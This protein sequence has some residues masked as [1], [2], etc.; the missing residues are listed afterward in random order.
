[1]KKLIM[2]IFIVSLTAGLYAQST[3][4]ATKVG[5]ELTYVNK[6]AKG[7]AT[8]YTKMIIKNVQGSGRNMTI[9]YETEL[10]DKNRK[11]LNPPQVMPLKVV[12]KDNV[13]TLDMKEMFA[14]PM[15]DQSIQIEFTGIP[16][17]IP[18]NIQPGQ[19][20]KDSEMTMTMDM[21]VMK[22]T[23]VVKTTD[24]KCEAIEDVT[25]PA[26]TFKCHKITQTITTT[27]MRKTSTSKVFTW[28]APGVGT[29]KT[30]TYDSKSKLQGS[31]ELVEL[32]GN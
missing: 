25:V 14:S 2:I 12:I 8:S 15:Q 23:T 21:V 18:N 16:Q 32:K 22:M 5:T 17:E 28:Y 27:A 30:E 24:G 13:M 29:I 19:T 10:L 11:S 9:S 3:F 1:M 20:L 26:G 7:K 4:F 31:M 6:D